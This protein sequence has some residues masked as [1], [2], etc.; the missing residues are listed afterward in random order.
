MSA[1]T[2]LNIQEVPQLLSKHRRLLAA[3]ALIGGLLFTGAS[4]F[5]P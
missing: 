5:V 3:G 1:Q 2:P 4:S